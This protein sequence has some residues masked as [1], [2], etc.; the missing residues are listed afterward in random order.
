MAEVSANIGVLILVLSKPLLFEL[1]EKGRIACFKSC[2][3]VI[4]ICQPDRWF[5]CCCLFCFGEFCF[6]LS[7]KKKNLI[8]VIPASLGC[9]TRR[10]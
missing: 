3:M 5:G 2:V 6:V 1:T 7:K 4:W 9:H 10:R 8:S